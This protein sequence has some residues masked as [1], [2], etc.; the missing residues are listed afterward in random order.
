MWFSLYVLRQGDVQSLSRA[1]HG[2]KSDFIWPLA[3]SLKRISSGTLPQTESIMCNV[4][5][6]PH[7]GSTICLLY[8]LCY[9]QHRVYKSFKNS[10]NTH[11]SKLF[12][13][14]LIY[15]YS[16]PSLKFLKLYVKS[17]F[18]CEL[19]VDLFW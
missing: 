18:V 2:T 17:L 12:K 19:K 9:N 4:L 13:I 5:F 16:S 15:W 10:Q 6:S 1:N 11:K 3:P 14:N 8:T 7:G